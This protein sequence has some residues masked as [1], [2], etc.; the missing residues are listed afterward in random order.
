MKKLFSGESKL[1]A[2]FLPIFV[3]TFLL[4]LSGIVD[5]MMLSS[6]SDDAVGSVGST[7]TYLSMFFVLFAIIA[8]G[9]VAVMTQYIG[10]NKKGVAVQT[11]N[12]AI[13]LNGGFS[14][15]LS[16]ILGF[17][18]EIIINLFGIADNLKADAI[19]Y[20]RIVGGAC[21][22]NAL[23]T[24]YSSYLRSFDKTKHSLVAN[25]TGNAVNLILNALFLF[26]WH[27]G[28][29]GVAIAT[30]IGKIVTL[31]LELIF[32]KIYIKSKEYKER[33]PVK[34]LLYQIIKIGLPGATESVLYTIAMGI[35]QMFLN[36]MD[37]VGFNTTARTYAN[38][39]TNFSYC[40]AVAMA[41][42]N[43]IINGWKIGA[44]E[45]KECYKTTNKSALIGIVC[46]VGLELIFAITSMWFMHIFTGD[47]NMINTVQIIL[48]ID[49]ALEVGRASN[50]VYAKALKSAGDSVYP[51]SVAVFVNFICAVGGAYLFGIV[52]KLGVAGAYIGLTLDECIRGVF[53]FI[54]YKSGKW[55][56]KIL[57]KR[58]T[59]KEITS[60]EIESK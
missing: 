49:I 5:T 33:I 35:V 27:K 28:V 22:L 47:Q 31:I 52:F 12:I 45:I 38:Q 59:A 1:F 54:R 42:A 2:L 19:I 4:M 50:L 20:M 32:V 57:I 21:F 7:N 30:V 15:I 23:I 25:L 60:T 58:E 16:L 44:G 26:V 34:T 6:V 39:V 55:E 3:E 56:D 8:T 46:G 36:K 9:L 48:F 53:M 24:I 41:Q 29:M 40:V 43:V 11:K 13:I 18:A 10:A 51:A 17:G 37:S 14:I